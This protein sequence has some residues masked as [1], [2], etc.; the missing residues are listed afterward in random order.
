VS[1][2]G[3]SAR[4]RGKSQPL[5]HSPLPPSSPNT[6]H[7][8]LL[9]SGSTVAI[10]PLPQLPPLPPL[11]LDKGDDI[12]SSNKKLQPKQSQNQH[13]HTHSHP[14]M[15]TSSTTLQ[16]SSNIHFEGKLSQ[17]ISLHPTPCDSVHDNFIQRT[18]N[19]SSKS[20][21]VL[22]PLDFNPNQGMGR[23]SMFSFRSFVLLF[24][25]IW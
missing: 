9:F 3:F 18:T 22:P 17:F 7:H 21:D 24:S 11:K 25:W 8:S 20:C 13:N 1:I 14:T 6:T 19:L 23:Q 4:G 5:N 2:V 15:D 10:P 12:Q 16:T